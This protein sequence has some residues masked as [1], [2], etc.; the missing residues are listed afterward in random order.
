M[1]LKHTF[2]FNW[3]WGGGGDKTPCGN[4][5]MYRHKKNI[6][7]YMRERAKRASASETYILGLQI[8]LH[9]QSMQFPFITYGM[10]LYRQYNDK[11]L[12]NIEYVSGRS[13][14][15]YNFFFAFSH[16]KTAISFY[17][18]LVLVTLCLRNIYIFRSQITPA[19]S[20]LLLLVYMALYNKRYT[21]KALTL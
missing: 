7:I 4:T 8:D 19:G 3:Y 5:H 15:A 21:D 9:V 6:Y 13:E 17:I 12:L 14:R 11:I 2:I 16:S 18:L 1:L 10:A 20:F